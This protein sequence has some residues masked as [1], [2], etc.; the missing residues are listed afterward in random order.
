MNEISV[1]FKSLL[2]R[3]IFKHCYCVYEK[4]ADSKNI[5]GSAKFVKFKNKEQ[6]NIIRP[7][8]I[9]CFLCPVAMPANFRSDPAIF[10]VRGFDFRT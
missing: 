4:L 3:R 2:Y 8:V 6:K 9:L 7:V 1:C 5:G 10:I